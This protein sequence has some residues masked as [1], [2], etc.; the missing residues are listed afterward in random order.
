M[1]VVEVHLVEGYSVAARTRLAQALT[2]TVRT[3]VPAEPELV[4]VMTHVHGPGNYLRGGQAR[5]GA[6]ELP[7][8]VDVVQ[9]FLAAM[10]AREPAVADGF[11]APGFEMV[12]PGDVRMTG[13]DEL[14]AWAAPRYRD[15]RKRFD[16]FD[17][18]GGEDAT[19]VIC[20]GT[21]AGTWPDGIKFDGIRFVDRFELRGGRIV[22][23]QVWNDLAE[24]RG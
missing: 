5:A 2:H 17:V 18:A 19:V 1:P 4:T 21:L 24:V 23:Q 22:R 3:V 10:E 11:L 14:I 7:D 16:G 20:H 8:P 6:A 13:L 9:R 15:V 12:F